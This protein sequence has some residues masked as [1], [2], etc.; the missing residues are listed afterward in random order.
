M[1]TDLSQVNTRL[2]GFQAPKATE[3]AGHSLN[4]V[5]TLLAE[6]PDSEM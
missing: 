1:Q 5:I 2:H 6:S 4:S 3:A